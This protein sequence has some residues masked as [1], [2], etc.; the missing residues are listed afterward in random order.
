M[1]GRLYERIP[2]VRKN[3]EKIATRLK[4]EIIATPAP[5][6]QQLDVSVFGVGDGDQDF[7]SLCR[8]ITENDHGVNV[9][10]TIIDVIDSEKEIERQRT[11][12]DAVLAQLSDANAH[13]QNAMSFISEDSS[14][15]GIEDQ[16]R[17]I[18]EAI[19]HIRIWL[20]KDA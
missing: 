15:E 18:D 7:E 9:I 6:E 2:E 19:Q 17:S 1:G 12:E 8:A 13:L 3:L 5:L 11:K 10:A 4:Q 20:A 16:L 14:K